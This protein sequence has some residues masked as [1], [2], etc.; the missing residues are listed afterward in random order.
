MICKPHVTVAAIVEHGGKFLLVE[1][2][3]DGEV[4]LNQP[5]GHWDEGES[6]L[7]AVMR[8]TLEETGWQFAPQALLGA[9][10]WQNPRTQI[11]YLRFAFTGRVQSDEPQRPLDN[12]ILRTVW[13]TLEEI[14][15]AQPR[16]R[17][18]QVQR[19]V[20]DFLAG[21]HYPLSFINEVR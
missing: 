12:G 16:H 6:L 20:D 8:E 7:Q 17:S 15:Q 14:R 11:T 21:Q 1:E 10:L 4:V 9:Y 18:P 3:A 13:M 2:E 19:C 5:A